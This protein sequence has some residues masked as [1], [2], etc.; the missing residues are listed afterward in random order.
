MSK[1]RFAFALALEELQEEQ[2]AAA[3]DAVVAPVEETAV[4]AETA[5][6]LD[7]VVETAE[8]G[9]AELEEMDQAATDADA[10]DAIADKVEEAGEGDG[11]TPAAAEIVEIAVENIYKRWNLKSVKMP[12]TEA[13]GSARDRKGATKMAAESISEQAKKIWAAIMKFFQQAV[14]W[15]KGFYA[16]LFDGNTK[17]KAAAEAMSKRVMTFSSATAKE[18]EIAKGGF[19]KS[20]EMGGKFDGKVVVAGVKAVGEYTGDVAVSVSD[21]AK[22]AAGLAKSPLTGSEQVPFN[23]LSAMTA[24]NSDNGVVLTGI[25]LPGNKALKAVVPK[26]W[27]TAVKLTVTEFSL[28]RVS[29]GTFDDK[30]EGFKGDKVPTATLDEVS[31]ICAAVTDLTGQV[32]KTK[33]ASAEISKALAEFT[34]DIKK[35]MNAEG[36]AEGVKTVQKFMQRAGAVIQ[37]VPAATTAHAVKTGRA[38]LEYGNVSLK[39]YK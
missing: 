15:V 2:A 17:L 6:A 22:V 38:A 20:L 31:A 18:K 27:K 5:V 26:D 13:F 4:P 23:V 12:A 34:A 11:L 14:E 25:E 30:A 37:S 33:A 7:E 8:G 19:V 28:S 3:V 24:S 16:K 9:D 1:S 36:A 39:Q 32:D 21:F 35:Q 10:L 29:F